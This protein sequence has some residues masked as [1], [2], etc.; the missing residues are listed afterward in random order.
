[1]CEPS[2]VVSPLA[3]CPPF[4][5][6][7]APVRLFA[8]VAAAPC[9]ESGVLTQALLAAYPDA[10]IVHVAAPGSPA[11]T[12]RV[13]HL[14]A[15]VPESWSQLAILA[16]AAR[17]NAGAAVLRLEIDVGA[18]ETLGR[19]EDMLRDCDVV[20][21]TYAGEAA[22][23]AADAALARGFCLAWAHAD[24]PNFGHAGYLNRRLFLTLPMLDD[25][26][27]EPS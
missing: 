6:L 20:Y 25:L 23:R 17:R 12:R 9:D 4:T 5:I 11:G 3:D 21:V 14:D 19:V 18:D 13:L 8:N 16:A 10:G 26:A 1:M 2:D 24:Q 7:H 27:I 15:S 22:R